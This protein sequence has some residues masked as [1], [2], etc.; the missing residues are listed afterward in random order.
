MAYFPHL[1]RLAEL[2]LLEVN[3]TA[4]CLRLWERDGM[5]EHVGPCTGTGGP[6]S[7][8]L[9]AALARILDDYQHG[10]LLEVEHDPQSPVLRVV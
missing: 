8:G 2:R 3:T 6:C 9:R 4:P 10:H 1:L 7:C 5:L